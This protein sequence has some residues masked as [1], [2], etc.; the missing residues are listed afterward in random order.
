MAIDFPSS[1]ANNDVYTD[2]TSG[3]K[4]T[5]NNVYSYWAFTGGSAIGSSSNTY[6]LF[7]DSDEVNGTSGFTFNKSTNTIT[8]GT[9]TVNTTNYSGTANNASFLG[10]TAAASY[11]LNS[12][13]AANVATMAANSATYA[14]ASISNTFTVGTGTYFVANGNVGIGNTAPAE[15]LSINGNVRL[16]G[17]GPITLTLE[18]DTD[19]AVETDNPRIIFKQDGGGVNGRI[20]YANNINS[21]EFINEFADSLILGTNNTTQFTITSAGNIG[22]GNTAPTA[23][24]HVTGGS[25]TD[26]TPEFKIT[27]VSGFIDFHNSL[28]LGAW[29][30][31]V[32]ADDKAIIF[33][34]G[35]AETGNFVI[36]PWSTTSSGIKI[37]SNGNVGIGNTA[38]TQKLH[39]QGTGLATDDFRAPIFYDSANTSFYVDPASTS[40]LN[41]V[42]YALLSGPATSTRDKIRLWSSTPYSIGMQAS[43][44]F[45]AI[46]NDYAITFQMNNTN[47]RGFWWGDDVHTTAQGAMALSTDGKLTVAHSIRVGHGES[48]T[49]VPGA[50]YRLDVSGDIGATGNITAYYSDERLKTKLGN[51][52]KAVDIIKSLNGFRYV[53]NETAKSFGYDSDKLQVGVSAQE[54]ERVLPEIVSIAPFDAAAD[55]EGNIISKTGENYKT[56]DYSKLVPVL[57]E[58]IKEQQEQIEALRKEINILKGVK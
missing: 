7:N 46:D 35:T 2:P 15:K 42:T 19:N 20:G 47:A 13:L 1:P 5:W 58:A 31:I 53:N 26:A 45:G 51:I 25:T 9:A 27:G 6:V 48:D 33:S 12:T 54:V 3:N 18:A 41:T 29:N 32:S 38:P 52:S 16:Y 28:S 40:V 50:T 57:I 36:A 8:I 11:Q 4:Y 21:L 22:V 43:I 37:T 44:T 55:S 34:D 30:P 14:N 10:G 23:K 49:T 24:L 56:V 39:V 17:T